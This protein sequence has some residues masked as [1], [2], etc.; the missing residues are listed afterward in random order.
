MPSISR[1]TK[2]SQVRAFPFSKMPHRL[3]HFGSVPPKT[4]RIVF[5][6]N[7]PI[8]KSKHG[9]CPFVCGNKNKTRSWNERGLQNLR[10]PES[11]W[12]KSSIKH[13]NRDSQYS[14]QTLRQTWNEVPRKKTRRWRSET[15][16]LERKPV[17]RVLKRGCTLLLTN[18]EFVFF[19][20]I[21]F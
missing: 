5:F 2:C 1:K 6:P 12:P 17:V 14:V 3:L 21:N 9:V 4:H 8:Y 15:R 20:K 19:F 13:L 11:R 10:G 18:T 16:S 7:H